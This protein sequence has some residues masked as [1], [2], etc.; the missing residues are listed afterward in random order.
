[1]FNC[2][3]KASPCNEHPLT[4]H[5]YIVK[6]GCAGVNFFLIFAPK[7]RLCVLVRIASLRR[8]ERVPTINVLSKNKKNVK[9]FHLKMN[10][11]TAVKYCCIS[12]GHACVM[13]RRA[14][15]VLTIMCL[16]YYSRIILASEST[17]AHLSQILWSFSQCIQHTNRND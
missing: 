2:I 17:F 5:F 16:S 8:F 7:H 12:H 9:K 6:L 13:A 4:H 1:M 15:K 11:F 14:Y 10:I 3:T